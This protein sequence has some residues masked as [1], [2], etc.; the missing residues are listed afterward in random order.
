MTSERILKT[1]ASLRLAVFVLIALAVTTAWGT[2]VEAQYND[3]GAAQKI[4][5][6]SIWMYAVMGLLAV[7]LIA[8]MVD[9][10]P[11][12]A[13]HTAFVLAHIGIL[14]LMAGSW[15]TQVFGVDGSL[16]LGVNESGRHVVVSQTD[17]ALYT[18]LDGSKYTKLFDREVDFFK[19]PPT[20]EKPLEIPIANGALRILEY[21]PYALAN[22]KIVETNEARDGSAIRFQMQN[23]NVNVT[24]WLHQ[25]AA[26]R[27]AE[28]DLGPA[29]IILTS[30][31][32]V[33]KPGSNVIQL[34]PKAD[35]KSLEY[36]IHSADV[37]KAV[38]KGVVKAGETIETGWMGL[39][40][41]VLKYLPSAKE[42]VTFKSVGKSTPLTTAAVRVE[43]NGQ[44]YWMAINSLLKLFGENELYVL[45][46]ANRRIDIGFPL[47]LKEFRMGRYPGTMRAA[48]YESVVLVPGLGG[49]E[50]ETLISMNE[51]LKQAGYTFYQASFSEDEQGRPVVSVLSVNDDPGRWIKYLGSLLIVLGTIHLFYFRRREAKTVS[52]EG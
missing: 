39:V 33:K 25:A 29:K 23:P 19:E 20:P 45:T 43:Y 35:K 10:W 5:Y 8:V 18:T 9:R 49:Q 24:E 42:D 34:R 37:K 47:K 36:E 44:S 50:R 22:Q 14:I 12:K 4:V 48:S 52:V 32:F 41:R 16:S 40:L 11:W 21:Y 17:L 46:Y 38:R 27:E 26:G 1:L 28:K 31:P 7:N 6:K 51:P 30:G 13:R 2:I 3:A 15:I